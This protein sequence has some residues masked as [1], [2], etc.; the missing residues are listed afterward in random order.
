MRTFDYSILP[1]TLQS[2]EIVSLLL[3]LREYKGKQ[4]LWQNTSPDAL[5]ALV[6]VAKAQSTESS[7][8]IEGIVTTEKRLK[9][10][11]AQKV[12]PKNRDER[13]IAGY[14]DVL[15]LIHESYEGIQLAPN[16]ILQLHRDLMA[17]T[18]LEMGGRWKDSDNVIVARDAH[19]N[20]YVRFR[21][22]P[23]LL[24]PGAV[25]QL[26]ETYHQAL[27]IE[28]YDPLLLTM[29]FIFD[30]V[31]IHP[32]GDG[33]GRM[34]RLL[35]VLATER[36]GYTVA[37][38]ISLEKLI[39]RNKQLYY[40]VLAE[41]SQGWETGENDEAPFVR[42]MLGI[43]IAAYRDLEDRMNDAS[44]GQTKA[45]RVRSVFNRRLGNVS[46][47]MILEECPDISE[48]TVEAALRGLL[49]EG[50]IRKIGRGRNTSYVRLNW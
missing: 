36:V 13:E 50:F 3:V 49:E 6:Q 5:D 9:E 14:R 28:R 22:M 7:N 24:T 46:K 38:F 2:N 21:P 40:E 26:C 37:R 33:N 19:G 23:A 48:S 35:T 31:S 4:G 47:A 16:V 8:R 27:S 39:E 42:F 20:T 44:S 11:M 32:F 34:S 25:E 18:G 1:A 10:L 45:E 12:S 29:R 43:M 41:S 15:N 17:H 30:F